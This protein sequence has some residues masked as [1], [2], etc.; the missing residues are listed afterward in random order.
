MDE[1]SALPP[2]DPEQTPI[3]HTVV[4]F[5]GALA[6]LNLGGIIALAILGRPIP[7]ILVALGSGSLGAL[8]GVLVPNPGGQNR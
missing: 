6:V 2:H 7:D 4:R 5:L 1:T 8:A 3:Y